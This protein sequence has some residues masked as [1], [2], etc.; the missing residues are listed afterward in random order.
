MRKKV[1][2]IVLSCA[3]CLLFVGVIALSVGC[4]FD[5]A[6]KKASKN[7]TQYTV[8]ADFDD[9]SKTI[10]ARQEVDYINKTGVSLDNICFHLYPRAFREN[11]TVKPYTALTKAR[12]FPNG[13]SFGDI[14]ITAVFVDGVAGSFVLDGEDEDILKVN[15]N[16]VL[17]DDKRVKISFDFT[18]TLAN[19]THRLGYF[20][21]NVNLGN[22]YPIACEFVD[23]E[24]DKT[25]YYST[26]DPFFSTVANYNVTFTASSDYA[27][28]SS[29]QEVSVSENGNKKTYVLEGKAI[30]DF[31]IVMGKNSVKLSQKV[32]NTTINYYAYSDDEKTQ[33][34]LD[35]AARA[36]SFFN[37]SFGT[38]PYR[39]LNV[40]KT[41][42][43]QGG[44]EY[45]NLVMISDNIVEENEYNKVIVHEIAHQWWYGVCGNNEVSDAWFDE[46]LSE[47]STFLFFDKY[48]NYLADYKDLIDDALVGYNLY[49]EVFD[50]IDIDVKKQMNLKVN[51]YSNEYEYTYMI[52]VKGALL[53]DHMA[54]ELGQKD[55]LSGLKKVYKK[56]KFG[57]VDAQGFISCFDDKVS[58][59]FYEFL[60]G[61]SFLDK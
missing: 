8:V 20:E 10:S 24:I 27:V 5:N 23:G 7:L 44:M 49:L 26:G 30:R 45:P 59:V 34:Y 3:F 28:T 50:S 4:G 43:M 18:L 57:V 6:V 14:N 42:F 11:A 60:N 31:A 33:E 16:N 9:Q 51:E 13:D 48:P 55:F 17:E 2:K 25:P 22:W 15:L 40:I 56:F 12:C 37:E 32:G 53:F 41:P 19:C 58:D 54:E 36:V 38:Y 47:Y 29:G 39:V 61:E 35:L 21:N 1:L 46:G 52:Y